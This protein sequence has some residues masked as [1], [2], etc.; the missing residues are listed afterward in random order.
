[1]SRI[2]KSIACLAMTGTLFSCEKKA[3]TTFT[4]APDPAPQEKIQKKVK[5]L[6]PFE[7]EIQKM[8]S[9]EE[10]DETI[11][12][13]F[14]KG[15]PKENNRIYLREGVDYYV[16]Q[17]GEKPNKRGIIKVLHTLNLLNV[18]IRN[19]EALERIKQKLADQLKREQGQ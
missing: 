17:H 10:A 18:E 1:M 11:L 15:K 5:A 12:R 8:L 16:S 4:K 2:I 7:Q 13:Q 14:L 6:T 19:E 9:V 3:E